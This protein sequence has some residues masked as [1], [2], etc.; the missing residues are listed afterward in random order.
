M[1]CFLSLQTK[2]L[3]INL[4]RQKTWRLA[5]TSLN[6]GHYLE[7]AKCV[8]EHLQQSICHMNNINGTK[9]CFYMMEQ[10]YKVN[11]FNYIQTEIEN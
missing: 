9:K 4:S 3:A 8:L 1:L 7:E 10:D 5:I 6:I 2:A 11:H